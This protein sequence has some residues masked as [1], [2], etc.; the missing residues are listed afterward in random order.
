[1]FGNLAG[2]INGNM[3]AG[4]FGSWVFVRLSEP[5]RAE[6]LAA[7]GAE[8]FAPMEGRPMKEYVMLPE[9]WQ[10]DPERART[11]VLRSFNWAEGLSPKEPK[12][13]E[14]K[15]KRQGALGP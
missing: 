7:P 5:D 8:V 6:L 10:D 12:D 9:E 11:W 2:F 4:V 15:K 14:P 1:M 13:K 3:F